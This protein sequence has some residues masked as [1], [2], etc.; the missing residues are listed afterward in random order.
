MAVHNLSVNLRAS[1]PQGSRV[2]H[3][4][5]IGRLTIAGDDPIVDATKSKSEWMAALA[6]MVAIEIGEFTD[7]EEPS[8]AFVIAL[9]ERLV[10]AGDWLSRQ[11]IPVF[12]D[13]RA[14]GLEC[15]VF[16]GGWIDCDQFDLDLPPNFLLACGE[17]GLEITICTND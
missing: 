8:E 17:R 1:H 15:D 7:A 4:A 13:I 2:S 16:V 9:R 3:D 14:A 10:A 12:D 11:P 5:F 6:V